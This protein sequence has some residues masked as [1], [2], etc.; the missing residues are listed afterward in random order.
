MMTNRGEM[1]GFKLM[2]DAVADRFRYWERRAA[3]SDAASCL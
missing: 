1:L 3:G 2:N